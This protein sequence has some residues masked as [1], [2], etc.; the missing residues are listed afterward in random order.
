MKTYAVIGTGAIGGYYGSRLALNGRTVNFLAR[1]DYQVIKDQ[2]LRVDSHQGN[3]HLKDVAVYNKAEDMPASDVL[4]V[5]LKSTGNNRLKDLITPLLHKDSAILILQNGL[6]IEEELKEMFPENPILGG[7]CF[8]CSYKAGPGHIVHQ[9]YGKITLG[10][11]DKKDTTLVEEITIDMNES[12]IPATIVQDLGEARWRKLLWNIPYNGL[13][14]QLNSRTDRIMK[15]PSSRQ[16]VKRLMEE[17]IEGASACGYSIE[18]E[19]VEKMMVFTDRM[20]PYDPSMKLDFDNNRPMEL[21]YIYEKP[22]ETTGAKG[23]EMKSV[24]MLYKHLQFL[25]ESKQTEE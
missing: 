13:C 10:S 18:K 2:G 1:S 5:A 24:W 15:I 22:L 23:Y 14:V 4:L 19:A 11:L 16:M 21:K 17:V 7:M 25:E 12:E 8:I 3:Y 6:G 9:D 20:I